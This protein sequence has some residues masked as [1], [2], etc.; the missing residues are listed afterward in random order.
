MLRTRDIVA[1]IMALVLTRMAWNE[2]MESITANANLAFYLSRD[3]ATTAA[4]FDVDGD[5]TTEALA[6]IKTTDK[7]N[8]VLQIL[9][10]KPLH[11]FGKTHLAPFRPSVLFE[12]QGIGNSQEKPLELTTGQVL[13][14]MGQVKPPKRSALSSDHHEYDD[15]TRHYFCGL[16]WHD[17][18]SKCGTPCPDGQGTNCPGDERC[19]ADTPCNALATK[20]HLEET[21]VLFQLTPGGGTFRFDRTTRV[22]KA[23]LRPFI[24]TSLLL[25]ISIS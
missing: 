19:F 1:A 18:A 13:V 5:G 6:V 20:K 25:L 9:D 23:R 12:S 24:L 4:P 16:D 21:Q 7:G 14:Q 10:L 17:A 11:Q 15:R 22:Y 3:G 8:W 2:N